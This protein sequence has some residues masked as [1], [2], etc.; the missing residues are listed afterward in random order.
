MKKKE[1]QQ[2]TIA[3]INELIARIKAE[4]PPRGVNPLLSETAIGKDYTVSYPD[5]KKFSEFPISK[6]TL[7]S[8]TENGFTVMTPIQRAIIPHCLIGRDVIGAA[9]TG[10]GK[11]LSYLIPLIEYMYRSQWFE[12]G[13]LCALVMA[14]TRELAQQIFDVYSK[15]AGDKYN[16]ALITGGK[17]EKLE[18]KALYQTNFLVCTPGR[19]L[20]HLENTPKFN[21]TP[22]RF[23]VLDEADR[24]L[25]MGFKKELTSILD[26]LPKKRQTLLFSATQT[27]SVKDLI[28]LS[29]THPEF[30]SVD[31]QSEFSTPENLKQFC[32][33]LKE[34]QKVNVLFSFLKTHTNSKIIVFFQTCK[35][36]RFF[37]ET[38]KQ[39]RCGLELNLL[40]G[41]QSANSRYSRYES[42]AELERGALFCTDIA[43]RGLDVKNV[44]WI[45]QYDCPEDTAQY[46]HRA[47]R[48]ARYNKAGNALLLLS[49]QQSSFVEKLQKV[50]VPIVRMMP[51][52]R[53][54]KDIADEITH[55]MMEYPFLKGYGMSAIKAYTYSLTKM[56]DKSI[57]DPE[58][59]DKMGIQA[60]YGLGTKDISLNALEAEKIKKEEDECKKP[61]E[62]IKDKEEII[63]E[64]Y[65]IEENT[66]ESDDDDLM[67]VSKKQLMDEVPLDE[68]EK[69]TPPKETSQ[70]TQTKEEKEESEENASSESTST[71]EESEKEDQKMEEEKITNGKET[72]QSTEASEEENEEEENDGD[73]AARMEEE[74]RIANEEDKQ[75]ER[76]RNRLRRVQERNKYLGLADIRIDDRKHSLDISQP[77]TKRSVEDLLKEKLK[78][79]S[80]L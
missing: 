73:F 49:E 19:L 45:I 31:E 10:S 76:E 59:V 77:T 12:R 24:I 44:D 68:K 74:V 15:I 7:K 11:T 26:Y 63:Q 38:F 2:N 47:G 6:E 39:L 62:V 71:S 69:V 41:K 3:E 23:L 67:K 34:R 9:K 72:T 22:L 29:L 55:L 58:K 57:F 17:D 4:A 52:K 33:I 32:L 25:D 42:F 21:V 50:K 30:I 65:V 66:S 16:A 35:Q 28:R 1:Q 20:Y 40:Y 54:L 14:P 61:T 51:N 27:K 8:L 13:G 53:M 48:T 75:R 60:A 78:G 79:S 70:E 18:A 37:F 56:S 64:K 5:A 80:L 43:S 36:V 46:I